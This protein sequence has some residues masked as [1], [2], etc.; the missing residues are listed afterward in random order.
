MQVVDGAPNS[1]SQICC[2]D[3][4]ED[5]ALFELAPVT[6]K[7]HQLRVH[8]QTLGWPILHDRYYPTLQ[9]KSADNY[10]QPLQLLAQQLSF[11]DP[12][13]Q[14]SRAFHCGYEMN[15]ATWSFEKI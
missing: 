1:H 11:I 6:G 8:M 7:T 3:R 5:K 10:A 14:R 12:V 4:F 15:S 2:L 9:P 13:T